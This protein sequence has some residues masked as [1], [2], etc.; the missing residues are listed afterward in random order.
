M[1]YD[2]WLLPKPIETNLPNPSGRYSEIETQILLKRNLS[3]PEEIEEFIHPT[4]DSTHDPML[5][6]GMHHAIS[7]IKAAANNYEQVGIFGDFDTDGITGTALLQKGL[8]NFGISAKTYIPDRLNE[9]HGISQ[10]AISFFRDQNVKLIITVDCGTTST[11]EIRTANDLG[12]DTIV[13]DHHTP[14]SEIP[15][16]CAIVNSSLPNCSYPFKYLTGVGTAFKLIEGMHQ[17]LNLEY[18]QSLLPLV[19]LGTISDVG[20]MR[21]ENRYMVK[22]GLEILRTSKMTG[23]DA[24]AN[25]GNISKSRFDSESLSF[26][27]IPRLNAA[28]RLEHASLSLDLLVSEDSNQSTVIAE[29]LEYLNKRRQKMTEQAMLDAQRQV[30]RL[31][32]PI[33]PIIFVGK[34]GWS[35]GILGLIAGRLAEAYQRPTIA[36]SGDS[37][38][39]RASARSIEA[40]NMIEALDKCSTFFD[41]YGGH[42]MAAGFQISRSQLNDFRKRMTSIAAEELA[43]H[44]FSSELH[45][46]SEIPLTWL[47]AESL[48]FL[49]S[50]EPY[51]QGNTEPIFISKEISVVSARTVGR[52]GA[53]LKL[54]L[55]FAGKLYDAIAFR[56]GERLKEAT[57]S[58][59]AVY[60]AGINHWNGKE[61]LQ[62]TIRD[63]RRSS[64]D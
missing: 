36:A 25:V 34:S 28:G 49:Q 64:Q 55:E 9:G 2:K 54:T 43:N 15:E 19:S 44:D 23:L 1:K 6:T 61:T 4:T 16:A 62:L 57:G 31:N 21:G 30:D 35:P 58:I 20:V 18:P 17:E 42:P 45:I 53:H 27:I 14:T 51:G 40:F 33:P 38:L 13:T 22:H 37:D 39:C 26:G 41:K 63:F 3:T 50:L 5:L 7:R 24:L 11:H 32:T 8:K 47:H 46:D 52:M 48:R 29:R 59:D 12:I 10:S 60:S 56:Q